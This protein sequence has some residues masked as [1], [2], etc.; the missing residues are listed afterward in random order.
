MREEGRTNSALH[1]EI[2]LLVNHAELDT[3]SH[4]HYSHHLTKYG[5]FLLNNPVFCS[6][7]EQ[8]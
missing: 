1:I 3:C 2:F 6:T 5:P 4:Q 8:L 7:Q